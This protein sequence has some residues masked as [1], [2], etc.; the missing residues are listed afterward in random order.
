L[1]KHAKKSTLE[2]QLSMYLALVS[3]YLLQ[4]GYSK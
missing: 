1:E 3:K 4:N 2:K